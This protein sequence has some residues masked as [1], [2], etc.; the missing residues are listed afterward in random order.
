M[1]SPPKM[2]FSAAPVKTISAARGIN[3]TARAAALARPLSA[4]TPPFSRR[5][6]AEARRLQGGAMLQ[7][8]LNWRP[9]RAMIGFWSSSAGGVRR[10][11]VPPQSRENRRLRVRSAPCILQRTPYIGSSRPSLGKCRGGPRRVPT[12]H[13]G[14]PAQ[15]HAMVLLPNSNCGKSS[16]SDFTTWFPCSI[17]PPSLTMVNRPGRWIDRHR[18]RGSP[19]PQSG[20][21]S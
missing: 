18:L 11:M 1:P 21:R 16:T 4:S 7:G 5:A 8:G 6:A 12:L 20:R 9:R 14:V 13:A 19:R 2:S 3:S 15:E 17:E 10:V